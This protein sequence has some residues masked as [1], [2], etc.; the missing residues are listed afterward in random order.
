M[1]PN[2]NEVVFTETRE[3]NVH[4]I[5]ADKE[6]IDVQ[7]KNKDCEND[8]VKSNEKNDGDMAMMVENDRF[9]VVM[10][11]IG[12]ENVH[13]IMYA[14]DEEVDVQLKIK[15]CEND[16]VESNENKSDMNEEGNVNGN[17]CEVREVDEVVMIE[18]R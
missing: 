15:D 13:A 6:E 10:V 18:I 17:E 4:A 8:V 1:S 9:D 11:E 12:E 5:C 16:V 3:G 14:V 2:E 7:F